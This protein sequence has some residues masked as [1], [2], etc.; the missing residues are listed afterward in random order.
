VRSTAVD[1]AESQWQALRIGLPFARA[2]TPVARA[3]VVGLAADSTF[4][5][6]TTSLRPL[7]AAVA[8]TLS[9]R[10]NYGSA[11]D[12]VLPAVSAAGS[13]TCLFSDNHFE[14][15]SRGGARLVELNGGAV[16]ASSN[17]LRWTNS[18]QD[19]LNI[20]GTKS[21]TVLGNITM[22]NIR[23][24]GNILPDPWDRLNVLAS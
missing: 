18:D 16:A 24:D 6:T 15:S 8:A 22:G 10:G 14:G 9:I 4:L 2:F 20:A 5:L 19:A 12:T 17:R 23:I 7:L 11:R 1:V 21:F 3:M 13:A